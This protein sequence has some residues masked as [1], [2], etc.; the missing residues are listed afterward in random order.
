M[1][2]CAPVWDSS[3]NDVPRKQG[4]E[5][6]S[7]TEYLQ[8]HR[9]PVPGPG[10]L[11]QLLYGLSLPLHLGRILWRDVDARRRYLQVCVTQLVVV[12][13]L[14]LVFMKS[15]QEVA[16]AAAPPK[17]PKP[18]VVVGGVP[19]P[20]LPPGPPAMPGIGDPKAEESDADDEEAD[21]DAARAEADA[22]RAEAERE[23]AIEEAVA[24]ALKEAGLS[25]Q[26]SGEAN[27]P[28]VPEP[29]EVP[30]K[31]QLKAKVQAAE[32]AIQAA[33]KKGPADPEAAKHLKS[34]TRQI[35][36]AVKQLNAVV[37]QASAEKKRAER[38][39]HFSRWKEFTVTDLEF[40]AALLAAMQITQWG[41]IAL[42]RDHH[43]AITQD[44]SRLTNLPLEDEPVTPRV[45]LNM[46]W[47]RHKAKSRVRALLIFS[48]GVPL[49]WV[50]T[51]W[52]PLYRHAVLTALMSAWGYWW[53]AVYTAGKS[54]RAWENPAAPEP[55]F[56][57]G[58]NALVA[59]VAQSPVRFLRGP[60]S[61]YGN[62]WATFT[63][64]MFSPAECVE[65]QPWV[66]AGLAV[67]RLLLALPGVKCFSRPLFPVAS[68][69]LLEAYRAAHPDSVPVPVAA[70]AA[71][72]VPAP[73]R[74]PSGG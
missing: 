72:P 11:E 38:R 8:A 12:T 43:K 40:W 30:S 16:D 34:A 71:E 18:H 68:A 63:R 22:A 32:A 52:V 53:F 6:R 5:A 67:A 33:L 24:A 35:N 59:R 23:R 70:L 4:R 47:L 58:W 44:L 51:R 7:M 15:G 54:A 74:I 41:V 48:V 9:L 28:E 25:E 17:P 42:S 73:A 50:S 10:V 29:P 2:G 36:G 65:R 64:S 57:R 21:A 14:G 31:D 56:L 27:S 39:S 55:W 69:H 13:G 37:K 46:P 45:R 19:L 49:L 60:L 3:L 62:V 20:P 1:L 26:G 61:A 66:F